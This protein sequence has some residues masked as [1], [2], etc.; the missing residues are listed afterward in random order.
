MVFTGLLLG[1]L[2]TAVG[3]IIVFV[4]GN[5]SPRGTVAQI[6]A[7]SSTRP[8]MAPPLATPWRQVISTAAEAECTA[9]IA[10]TLYYSSQATLI[11]VHAYTNGNETCKAEL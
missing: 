3:L 4:N 6:N 8:S 9:V 1:G 5:V 11:S 10:F 2:T 7:I